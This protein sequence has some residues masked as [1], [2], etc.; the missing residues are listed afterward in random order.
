MRTDK[1]GALKITLKYCKNGSH[2]FNMQRA[3][4]AAIVDVGL[5]ERKDKDLILANL[6]ELQNVLSFDE[7]ETCD[8]YE[9]VQQKSKTNK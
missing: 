6:E 4:T 7:L 5:S 1:N 8:F 3:I 2:L 9:T